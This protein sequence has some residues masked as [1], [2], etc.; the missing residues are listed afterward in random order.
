M[1]YYNKHLF[2]FNEMFSR[3]QTTLCNCDTPFQLLINF[4]KASKFSADFMWCGSEFHILGPKLL[5]LLVP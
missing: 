1:H 2:F 3:P 4:L 5:R